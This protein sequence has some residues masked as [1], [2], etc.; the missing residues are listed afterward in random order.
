MLTT[1]PGPQ[2]SLPPAGGGIVLDD[3]W[4]DHDGVDALRGVSARIHPHCITAVAGPNGSGKSTLLGVLAGIL[5]P[6][7]GGVSL[8]HR[9]STALVVQRSEVP[10]R[11][12]LTVRDV[13][14][15]GR[16]ADVGLWRRLRRTD[17]VIIDD[18][19]GL[20]GLD[21]YRGRPLHALSGGQRQRAFLAQGLA[22]QADLVLLDEPTTGLDSSSRAVVTEVLAAE[23]SRGATV[24]CVSHDDVAL[25]AADHLL[26]LDAGCVVTGPGT[27][28]S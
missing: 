13:V 3:V 17:Q 20:V 9:R 1:G 12:P 2:L 22:R 14:A 27:A 18:C 16:W 19:I 23:K 8:P 11:I 15:M 28:G 24:V 25:R 21:G 5:P 7:S 4:V 26:R 6:R 10:D